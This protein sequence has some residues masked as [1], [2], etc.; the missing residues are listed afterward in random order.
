MRYTST[1]LDRYMKRIDKEESHVSYITHLP[2]PE[3]DLLFFT[4]IHLPP[5]TRVHANNTKF[6]MIQH[7]WSFNFLQ[8][9]H[10][11][12]VELAKTVQ[13]QPATTKATGRWIKYLDQR[14]NKNILLDLTAKTDTLSE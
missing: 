14:S 3:R 13:G 10:Y 11:V 4:D 5:I 12:K 6:V 9:I 1:G 8:K 2:F 7:F